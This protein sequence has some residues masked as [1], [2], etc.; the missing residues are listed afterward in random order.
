MRI[1]RSHGSLRLPGSFRDLR[2]TGSA[3]FPPVLRNLAV[4]S[5][6]TFHQ[7]RDSER[8]RTESRPLS[9]PAKSELQA[10]REF[11]LGAIARYMC[12]LA[13]RTAI[14]PMHLDSCPGSSAARVRHRHRLT[15]G[16]TPASPAVRSIALRGFRLSPAIPTQ[17]QSATSERARPH[18]RSEANSGGRVR[19]PQ[20]R[21][22]EARLIFG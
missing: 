3:T 2:Y 8:I 13:I 16:S 20:C 4:T 9:F 1:W 12:H 6:S 17:F 14:Q 22:H 15:H 19:A 21:A 10:A 7:I 11:S 18:L 5:V